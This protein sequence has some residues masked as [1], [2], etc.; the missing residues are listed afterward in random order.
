MKKVFLTATLLLAVAVA[1]AEPADTLRNHRIEPVVVQ[2]FRTPILKTD[3]PNVVSVVTS[4]DIAASSATSLA[5]IVKTFTATES[6]D[7]QGLNNGIELRA[8]GV[9][10]FSTSAYTVM[11]LDGLRV[12]TRNPAVT[13]TAGISSVEVLKGPFS[14]V[15]GSGAMG[16]IINT[17]TVQSRGAIGGGANVSYGSFKTFGM[18]AAVGGSISGKVDFDLSVDYLKRGANYKTGNDNTLNTTDYEKEVLDPNAYDTTYNHTQFDKTVGVLRLGWDVSEK[19]RLNLYNNLYYTGNAASNGTLWGTAGEVDKRVVR[20]YHRLDVTGREGVHTLRLS[21]FVSFESTKNKDITGFA[22]GEREGDYNTYGFLAQDAVDLGFGSLVAGV[23]NLS[24]RYNSSRQDVDG[25]PLSPFQPDYLNAQTGV[26]AQLNV[27]SAD[28]RFSAI[29]GMRYD[30]IVIKTYRTDH[31]TEVEPGKRRYNT[32]NSNYSLQYRLLRD[33]NLRVHASMGSAFL[34]PDAFKLLGKYGYDYDGSGFVSRFVG[35]PNLKPETS[36]TWEAGVGY[37]SPSRALE[38][39]LSFFATDHENLVGIQYVDLG[40]DSYNTYVNADRAFF[41]GLEATASFDLG[42]ALDKNYSWR[43][44]GS[45]MRI[46]RDQV[47]SGD[48]QS[49]RKYLSRTKL[50]VGSDFTRKNLTVALQSRYIGSKTE[51]DF[52]SWDTGRVIPGQTGSLLT[53]PDYMVLD[54]S[55]SYRLP[56]GFTVGVKVANLLNELYMERDG[57]YMPG[58]NFSVNLG[59]KF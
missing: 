57:Y 24:E 21:P 26:F 41:R 27:R 51:D 58:R 22:Q 43:F 29:A 48:V 53:T 12:G 45:W 49:Q 6:A 35:N 19:W 17:N 16:G 23:D 34:A 54:A 13:M 9:N 37:N 20:D 3:V 42:A 32:L 30:N 4:A 47:N 46:F 18:G 59:Y 44:F 55:A 56:L 38:A 28:G 33:K 2:S 40:A 10:A 1:S 25:N 11:L 15:Y 39:D 36:T 50:T 8:F 7:V 14:A 52:V 5:E 31:I